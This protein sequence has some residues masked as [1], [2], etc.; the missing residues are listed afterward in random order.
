MAVDDKKDGSSKNTIG[1]KVI[2]AALD[3]YGID[4]KYV[5]ASRYDEQAKTA[6]IVTNGGSKVSFKTGDKPAP[7]SAI[8][9]SGINPA[10]KRKPITGGKK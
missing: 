4:E 2:A 10:A 7:L 6:I 8:A 9:V 5:V 3:A 1:D